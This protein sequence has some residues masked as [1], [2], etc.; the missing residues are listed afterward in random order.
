MTQSAA[1]I[2]GLALALPEKDRARIA[3]M[4]TASLTPKS[5]ISILP[6]GP[7]SGEERRRFSRAR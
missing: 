1:E 4:L 5:P 3:E 2:L 6:G 7:K